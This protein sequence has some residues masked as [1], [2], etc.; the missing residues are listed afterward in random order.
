MD[1]MKKKRTKITT[2]KKNPEKKSKRKRK[3]IMAKRKKRNK[4]QSLTKA[5]LKFPLLTRLMMRLSPL[6][7]KRR[8][9]EMENNLNMKMRMMVMVKK[10]M[11]KK[12]STSGAKKATT[13]TG[14][15]RRIR[16]PMREVI[17]CLTL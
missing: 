14:T 4:K 2:M 10:I 3:K 12:A 9:A 7:K 13:G 16:R 5:Q 6:E 17:R 8:K 1:K 15:T 11:T